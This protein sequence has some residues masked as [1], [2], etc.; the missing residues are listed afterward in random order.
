M[1]HKIKSMKCWAMSLGLLAAWM[2]L[3]PAVQSAEFVLQQDDKGITVSRNG[4]LLTR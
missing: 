1:L 3:S 2:V 4:K